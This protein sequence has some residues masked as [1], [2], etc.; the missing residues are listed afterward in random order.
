MASLELPGLGEVYIGPLLSYLI[1][2]V[3]VLAF[4][5]AINLIDGLDG[6]AGGVVFFATLT[7]IIVAL[8]TGNVLAAILNAALAGAVLGF[9]FYNFN[10]AKIFMGDTGSMFLGYALGSAPL[11]TGGQ[12]ESTLASLLVSVIALGLPFT[13][14]LLAMVR[15]VV[16]RQPIF[17]GDRGHF[18]HRL[19]DLGLTHRRAVLVL[20]G[21]SILLC[22]AAVGAALGRDWQVG[23][24]IAGAL[25]TLIA[26]TRFAGYFQALLLRD[27]TGARVFSASVEALRRALPRTIVELEQAESPPEAW[28]ALERLLVRGTFARAEYRPGPNEGAGWS[29]ERAQDWT[30]PGGTVLESKFDI[31]QFPGAEPASLKFIC[32]SE[33]PRFSAHAEI[34]MQLIA[35]S[36]EATLVRLHVRAPTSMIRLVSEAVQNHAQPVPRHGS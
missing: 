35:D 23:A 7:N 29:W 8:V 2:V 3:W 18:H 6:L 20:Y 21:C 24:A 26:M 14:T 5:N 13:D 32:V 34:L 27:D 36:V 33:Q 9:L 16:A 4:I 15:R 30:R 22:L 25:L 19:L 11:M 1:T 17:V 28:A 12:K 10:P 31:C